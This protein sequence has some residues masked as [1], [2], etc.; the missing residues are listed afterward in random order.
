MGKANFNPDLVLTEKDYKKIETLA[1]YGLT[2]D[3]IAG[4]FSMSK[5]TLERRAKKVDM[6]HAAIEEGRA[7]AAA[8]VTQSA[9]QMAVS[10]KVPAM[11]MFWLKTRCRWK[12]KHVIEAEITH[13]VQADK[14]EIKDLVRKDPCL[15]LA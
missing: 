2:M 13:K 11:T 4:V 8:R 5:D 9:Y 14:E 7:K 1:G 6:L 15:K 3:Q 10:G 12:E